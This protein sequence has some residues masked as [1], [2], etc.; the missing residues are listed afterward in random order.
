[1]K[2]LINEGLNADAIDILKEYGF[3][4]INN[5]F[6]YEELLPIIGNFD[7]LI[8]K[9]HTK[10][11]KELLDQGKQGLLKMIIRAGVGTD[12]ID[13]N[14]ADRLGIEI[15][16]TPTAS[17]NSVAEL[18]IGHLI[19]LARNINKSIVS[20]RSNEWNKAEYLG[21]EISGKT[22]GIIGFGRIGKCLAKKADA[23]GM[24]IIY[25][26]LYNFGNI[27]VPGT[28]HALYDLLSEADFV[29]IHTPY[30]QNP[31]IT[32]AEFKIMKP[33]AYLINIARGGV[34]DEEA[35]INALNDNDIK[36]AAIDVFLNEPC[37]DPRIC[38]HPNISVTPHLGGS[39][40]E[41]FERI[42]QEITELLY[43]M[44]IKEAI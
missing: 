42:G 12:N 10:V 1:M 19:V 39:T 22:L 20:L 28:Y 30:L 40:Q 36:G 24:K 38:K 23:L 8:V 31:I 18:A 37:P 34:V 16:N 44:K 15:C 2:I 21:T 41:A 7:V 43:P 14:H 3:E 27:N 17:T 33:T 13:I 26:D 32:E 4:I 29:S 35:L 11:N 9:S 6:T 5:K 25:N